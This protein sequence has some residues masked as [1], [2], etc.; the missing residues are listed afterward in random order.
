[1]K[2]Y[3]LLIVVLALLCVNTNASADEKA[4]SPIRI[5]V[6]ERKEGRSWHCIL[7]LTLANNHDFSIWFVFAYR[8]D[9]LLRHD[10]NF[11]AEYDIRAIPF[12]STEYNEGKGSAIIVNHYGK[13]SF[14][15]IQLPARGRFHFGGFVVDSSGP[16][17]FLDVWEVRSLM[18]NGVSP[19][20]KWLPYS[21]TSSDS[22]EISAGMLS[23]EPRI[24]SWD[25]KTSSNFTSYPD[26]LAKTIK[27][28][29]IRRHLI[30]LPE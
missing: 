9:T 6:K 27:A 5:E 2:P 20:Q 18:V 3:I 22:V 25:R 12:D 28:D 13:D 29:V 1:M 4:A 14:R 30:Q 23:R 7:D 26:E 17:R 21:V 10:G 24:V 19:L 8:G 11:S 16:I 15:A